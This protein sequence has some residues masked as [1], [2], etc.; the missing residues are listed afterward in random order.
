MFESKGI[1]YERVS[2]V[3]LDMITSGVK[4]TVRGVLNVTGGKTETVAALLR[5][6]NDKRDAEVSKMS[7]EIGSSAI[8]SLLASEVQI[9]VERKTKALTDI[10]ERQKDH[11]AEMIELLDE[12]QTDCDHHIELAEA[13]S[14]TAI[15]EST[16]KVKVATSRME[17]A[18]SAKKVAEKE[19][20]KVVTDTKDEISKISSEA[21]SMVKAAEQKAKELIDLAEQKATALVDSAKN[22]ANSLVKAANIQI[23]KAESETKV[24]RQQVKDFTVDQAKNEIE[25]IQFEQ[26][27]KAIDQ[28]QIELATQKTTVVKLE[29]EK[30][31]FVK[32]TARLERDVAE[33]KE[34]AEKLSKA[35]A[36]LVE[37][38][39]Q[40]SQTERD[41]S[42]SQR[43]RESLSQALSSSNN[44]EK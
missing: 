39:K 28:L 7:D 21:D 3:A 41:L 31:A 15:K 18:E 29:T 26:T 1:S 42:L 32:D 34:K 4:V 19:L 8:A 44:K 22:E 37:L 2:K 25:Q 36:Q 12:K 17:I 35:Q 43:E 30:V 20:E 33:T 14:D 9:V 38:Q 23:D 27:K 13:Q 5:D 24:L 10:V 40:L 11:I 6:F 16:E